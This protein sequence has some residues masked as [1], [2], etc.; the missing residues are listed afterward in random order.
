MGVREL[1][2]SLALVLSRATPAENN[3]SFI[4]RATAFAL[5]LTASTGER[6]KRLQRTATVYVASRW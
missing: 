6:R 5:Y 2:R 3:P 1:L 4:I